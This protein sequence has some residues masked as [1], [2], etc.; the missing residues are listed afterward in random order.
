MKTDFVNHQSRLGL[1]ARQ[2][3]AL[4]GL[5]RQRKGGGV[6]VCRRLK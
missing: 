4:S 5:E 6:D 1:E 2:P 3:D